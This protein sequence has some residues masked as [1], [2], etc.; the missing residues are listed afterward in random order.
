ML[1]FLF[2]NISDMTRLVLLVKYQGRYNLLKNVMNDI[3][4]KKVFFS[5]NIIFIMKIA[6][7][8][9]RTFC[10][11]YLRFNPFF[12]KMFFPI[13]HILVQIRILS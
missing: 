1:L 6:I 10:C 4:I 7:V 13:C 2:L 12:V 5:L 9:V 8:G 3:Y 11:Y